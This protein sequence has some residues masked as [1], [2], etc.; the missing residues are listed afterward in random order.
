MEK[1]NFF[2][3]TTIIVVSEAKNVV[4]G[5]NCLFSYYVVIRVSDGHGIY[6]TTNSERLNFAKS[7]FIGDHVWFG[8]NTF[9]FKGTQIHSGSIIGAGSILSNKVIP[10]NVTYAGNPAKLIKENTFWI[11][12]STQNWNEDDIEKMKKYN[13]RIFTYEYDNTTLDFNK[14]NED[15]SKLNAE[16][17][18]EYIKT[19]FLS[20]DK[21]RFASKSIKGK[22]KRRRLF[23]H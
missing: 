4:I 5:S 21:N 17:S 18:L 20:D 11:P 16:E 1:N 15:L 12:H 9:V 10:S 14:I 2:N 22:I 6:S 13:D 8:Q 23:K 3:G 7:I 19:N